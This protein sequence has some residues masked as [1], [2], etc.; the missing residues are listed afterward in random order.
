MTQ[1]MHLWMFRKE[2]ALALYIHATGLL[3]TR[4]DDAGIL[5]LPSYGDQLRVIIIIEAGRVGKYHVLRSLMWF[6][7]PLGWVDSTVVTSYQGRPVF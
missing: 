6:A 4:R 5:S 3:K 2:H 7:F 1:T